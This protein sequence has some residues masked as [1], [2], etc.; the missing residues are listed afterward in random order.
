MQHPAVEAGIV[1]QKGM[2]AFHEGHELRPQFREG[3]GVF[4]HG[5]GQ[6][7]HMGEQNT[8]GRR[9]DQAVK[10]VRHH[11]ILDAAKAH[12]AV[13]KSRA[14]YR[15]VIIRGYSLPSAALRAASAMRSAI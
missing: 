6:A 15:P 1:G 7:M 8:G 5:P 4:Q 14:T 2:A 11:A 3:G 13:S 9:T 12:S 10:A